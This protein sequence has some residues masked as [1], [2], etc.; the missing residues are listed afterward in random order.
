MNKFD[1]IN[2]GYAPG[3]VCIM[4]IVIIILTVLL[5]SC[6]T[7]KQGRCYGIYHPAMQDR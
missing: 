7:Q 5:A 6:G 3:I 1:P 4:L 2:N